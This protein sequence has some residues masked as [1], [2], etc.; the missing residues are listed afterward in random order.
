[1]VMEVQER[2]S[3]LQALPS[4]ARW[5]DFV[6]ALHARYCPNHLSAYDA[7]SRLLRP[8]IVGFTLLLLDV[9]IYILFN[10]EHGCHTI[11]LY[12]LSMQ[13]ATPHPTI[14]V[15]PTNQG[16]EGLNEDVAMDHNARLHTVQPTR[17][18]HILVRL[19]RDHSRHKQLFRIEL[20][21]AFFF[22]EMPEETH[23]A[24][25]HLLRRHT[26]LK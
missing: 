16:L 21:F 24:Q 5:T 15:V 14:C 19:Q 12:M 4:N 17:K 6:R 2:V 13:C 9:S 10:R 23:K 8:R 26:R 11:G 20:I 18:G 25:Q 22:Y 7:T 1:M 3:F